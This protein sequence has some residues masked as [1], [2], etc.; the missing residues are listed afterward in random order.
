MAEIPIDNDFI[1]FQTVSVHVKV[2]YLIWC[3]NDRV[4]VILYSMLQIIYI[5]WTTKKVSKRR[6]RDP[7]SRNAPPT[8]RLI[9]RQWITTRLPTSVSS[10]IKILRSWAPYLETLITTR[11]R[12]V[13]KW[14]TGKLLSNRRRCDRRDQKTSWRH[15]S[16][17]DV[18]P[19]KRS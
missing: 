4:S 6:C 12:A 15:F 13:S 9:V 10:T 7:A 16:S 19:R 18:A 14:T 5:C 11:L 17:V 2:H 3:Q 1:W 8:Q